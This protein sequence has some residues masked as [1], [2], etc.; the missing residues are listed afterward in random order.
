MKNI[1][2]FGGCG[3]LGSWITK[4]LL[5]KNLKITI[6]DLRIKTDLLKNLIGNDLNKINFIEGDISDYEQVLKA[7]EDMNYILNLAGLMT[8]DCSSNPSLGAEV[9]VKGSI[10]VFEAIKKNNIKFL[11]YTSS[12][13]VYGNEDKYNPFPETHYGAFK[14]AVEGMARAY[15]NE[16]LIS[17]VGLRPFVI[18]GPGREVGGTAGVTLACKAAKQNFEYTVGFSGKVGF[19]YV[20]DVTNL[21][22]RLID[23][24]PVGAITMNINGITTSVENFV[25]IIKKNIPDANVKFSGKPLSVVEEILGGEPSKTFKDFKYTSLDNGINKTINFY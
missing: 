5:K 10:N 24:A 8:P 12:G 13:G 2:I 9:N 6:F 18:Y 22:E 4:A 19:V 11:I 1:L 15:F 20:E 14:L 23:K 16:S 3:F 25:S 17:S 21:V 7:T